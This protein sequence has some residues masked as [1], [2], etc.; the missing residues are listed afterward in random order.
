MTKIPSVDERVEELREAWHK[1]Y[2]S[3]VYPK[4]MTSILQSYDLEITQAL[5][6]DRTNLLAAKDREIVEAYAQGWNEGQQA[7][8][9]K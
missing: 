6:A 3:S 5:T 1:R 4:K 9:A 7:L 8:S 2:S